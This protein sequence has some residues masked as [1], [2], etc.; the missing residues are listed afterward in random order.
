[1]SQKLICVVDV[2][3]IGISYPYTSMQMFL[4]IQLSVG[5]VWKLLLSSENKEWSILMATASVIQ[6]QHIA[7]L[8]GYPEFK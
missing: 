6:V 4:A 1:M 3:L 8:C 5:L 2:Y 7:L